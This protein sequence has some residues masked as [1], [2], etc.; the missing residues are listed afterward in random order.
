[1]LWISYAAAA[2]E[3]ADGRSCSKMAGSSSPD[4]ISDLVRGVAE[5]GMG[6]YGAVEVSRHK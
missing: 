6:L 2:C 3:F 5:L 4:V 1:M